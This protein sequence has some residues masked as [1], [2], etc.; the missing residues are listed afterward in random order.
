MNRAVLVDCLNALNSRFNCDASRKDFLTFAI[1]QMRL[2]VD[3]SKSISKFDIYDHSILNDELLE[4]FFSR[5]TYIVGEVATRCRANC[6][7]ANPEQLRKLNDMVVE[8]S[9]AILITLCSRGNLNDRKPSIIR[10]LDLI[11]VKKAVPSDLISILAGIHRAGLYKN[12]EMRSF[13]ENTIKHILSKISSVNHRTGYE[14]SIL[15]W[16]RA[17]LL[18]MYNGFISSNHFSQ[19][20]IMLHQSFHAITELA[21]YSHNN[22]LLDEL[23]TGLFST[24]G[25]YKHNPVQTTLRETGIHNDLVTQRIQK[26][27]LYVVQSLHIIYQHEPSVFY[28][29]KFELLKRLV[30]QVRLYQMLRESTYRGNSSDIHTKISLLLVE[31][32]GD[33]YTYQHEVAIGNSNYSIDTVITI[34]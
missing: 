7:F 20:K 15:L 9:S 21:K 16:H 5:S 3:L 34:K 8:A 30:K 18:F 29:L 1:N 11:D 13:T 27:L 2:V 10:L 24:S 32:L 14:I 4:K 17:A 31:I 23:S 19:L 33:N 28:F 22:T 12:F 26:T 25:T 6:K